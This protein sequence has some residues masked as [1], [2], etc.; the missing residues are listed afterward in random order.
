MENKLRKYINKKFRMY[1]K[2][3]EILEVREELFSIILDKYNDCRLSGLDGEHSYREAIEMMGDYKQAIR[4]VETG[5]SLS[6]LKRNVISIAAFS[7]FYF[8]MLTAAYLFVSMVLVD[9]FEHT[10]LIAVGGAFVYL[11]YF[12]LKVY[13]YAKLFNLNILARCGIG[14]VF[15]SLIPVFY[16]FPSLYVMVMGYSS[17]WSRSWIIILWILLLY[18]LTDYLVYRKGTSILF[19]GLHIIVAGFVLTTILYL[20]ASLWLGLWSTAWILFVAYLAL[21]SLAFYFIEKTG[22]EETK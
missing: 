22:K 2:T 17:I 11:V 7:T 12:S 3:K 15:L 9:T 13:Q 19:R 8:M 6:A 18:I 14:L 4:E 16:V 1:P 10:W 5:S 20:S 21:I